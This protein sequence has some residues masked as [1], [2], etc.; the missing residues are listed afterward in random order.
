LPPHAAI[1]ELEA[2]AASSNAE[3]APARSEDE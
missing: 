3:A 1:Q 2:K